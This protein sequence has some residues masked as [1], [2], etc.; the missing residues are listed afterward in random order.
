MNKLKV[1]FRIS[2]EIKYNGMV[3]VLIFED[4]KSFRDNLVAF[5]NSTGDIAVSGAY[6]D[7]RDAVSLVR[8]HQPDIV[9]MDIQMPFISGLE[10]LAL[11]KKA[12]AGIKVLIQSIYS[13]DE[14][15]FKAICNGA[16]GYLMKNSGPEQYLRSIREVMDGGSALSPGI[17]KKVLALFQEH[18]IPAQTEYVDLTSR[19]R[20]IL[21]Y[22]SKG[23]SYKM[24]ADACF[25]SVNTVG[26][27]MAHI[28]QKLHVNSATEALAIARNNKII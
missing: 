4:N 11:I 3:K 15:I 25:I 8:K 9:L 6:A 13:E 16:S 14:K 5:L 20:E 22:L 26:T 7:A 12:N 2:C 23:K 10:A 17:A 28:Y 18:F 19:E 24:I 21:I 27:H 1:D